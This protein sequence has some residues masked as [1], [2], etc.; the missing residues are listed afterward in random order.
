MKWFTGSNY[1]QDNKQQA[2]AAATQQAA[3]DKLK[4]DTLQANYDKKKALEGQYLESVD[5]QAEAAQQGVSRLEQAQQDAIASTRNQTGKVLANTRGMLG[6][7]R[8]VAMMRGAAIDRG[9]AE[10]GQRAQYAGA[11]QQAV[12]QAAAAK[13]EALAEQGKALKQQEMESVNAQTALTNA[14]NEARTLAQDYMGWLSDANRNEIAAK[15]RAK[16][17]TQATPAERDA[18]LQMADQVA[19]GHELGMIG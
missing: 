18:W 5:K 9:A 2:I 3:Q 13:S 16:A 12:Q 17:N 19:A 7:G 4:K 14:E 15:L 10:G 8:G 1:A 6:G 11:I